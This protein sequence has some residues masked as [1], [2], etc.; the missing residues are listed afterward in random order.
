MYITVIEILTKS[1]IVWLIDLEEYNNYLYDKQKYISSTKFLH[2]K[3]W[4]I[5]DNF[6]NR[7]DFLCH[8]F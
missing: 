3:L 1:K 4:T 6:T 2:F 8:I 5:F 7:Y